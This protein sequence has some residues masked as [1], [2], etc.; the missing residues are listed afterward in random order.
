M[1]RCLNDMD[2]ANIGTAVG[3][4]LENVEYLSLNFY[5]A[6]SCTV[7]G[8]YQL[9]NGI[10][11]KGNTIKSLRIRM[12]KHRYLDNES[13]RY[14]IRGI[15]MRL[16]NLEELSI[17]ITENLWLTPSGVKALKDDERRNEG[18]GLGLK[19]YE[20]RHH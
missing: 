19:K 13:A 6:R 11:G 16:V 8:I 10:S 9:I 15:R 2:L 12:R 5:R 4:R 1:C 18:L 14:L 3:S 7:Y 17:V 20:I